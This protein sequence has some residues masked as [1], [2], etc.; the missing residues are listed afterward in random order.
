MMLP[1]M[2]EPPATSS[3]ASSNGKAPELLAHR[4]R[5]WQAV[6]CSNPPTVGRALWARPGTNRKGQAARLSL[7]VSQRIV[8]VLL[9]DLFDGRPD[10]SRQLPDLYGAIGAGAGEIAPVRTDGHARHRGCVTEV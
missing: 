7:C 10:L 5:P 8:G 1:E 3:F 2:L 9:L 6:E 4:H